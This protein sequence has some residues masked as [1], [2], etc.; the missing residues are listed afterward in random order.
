MRFTGAAE[1]RPLHKYLRDR[2]ADT[3]VLTFAQV[4]DLLG[5]PL[6]EAARVDQAWWA[7]DPHHPS[8]QARVWTQAHRTAT[9]HL[10]ARTVEFERQL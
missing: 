8:T 7:T 1:Y 9:V 5:F 2:F 6:P 4:E 3:V 10:A